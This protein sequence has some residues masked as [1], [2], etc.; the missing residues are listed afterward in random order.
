[1]KLSAPIFRLK[2]QAKLLA[3]LSEA[4]L[5]TA[6]NQ[7]ARNEGF[8]TWSHLAA[9][10]SN[11][12]PANEMLAQLRPGD[13]VLLGARPGHGKTLQGL[14]LAVEAVRTGRP[15]FFFTLEDNE[16]VVFDR[17]H[18]LGADRKMIEDKLIVDTSDD[19]CAEH[20][21]DRVGG[22]NGGAVIIIDYLQLLDQRRCNPELAVQIRALRSFAGATG[23]II[24]AL[25]QIDRAFESTG[26]SLPELADIRLP[27]AFDLTL[28]T[29]ACFM[30]NGETHLEEFA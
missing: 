17:L 28:F 5:H 4:P 30:H 24:V 27:N 26:K 15:A 10:V 25:S 19:I 12:R 3:R 29:K 7:V 1:M 8:R 18:M 9:S 14:E 20:I 22:E 23:S 6:L 11:H 21:I 2:R 13:L 16:S